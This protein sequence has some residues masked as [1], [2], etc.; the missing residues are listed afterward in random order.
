[1]LWLILGSVTYPL[2]KQ[3]D[4]SDVE[5]LSPAKSLPKMDLSLQIPPGFHDEQVRISLS[6]EHP[7][8]TEYASSVPIAIVVDDKLRPSLEGTLRKTFAS[9][10]LNIHL[11]AEKSCAPAEPSEFK[12][13][14]NGC[15]LGT[16]T[17]ETSVALGDRTL[18]MGPF[19]LDVVVQVGICAQTRSGA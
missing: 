9:T 8:G 3:A 14:T 12:I 11:V 4:S 16:E 15:F 19:E 13:S 5:L 10:Y 18:K 1:V 6:S 7:N 2:V 17:C